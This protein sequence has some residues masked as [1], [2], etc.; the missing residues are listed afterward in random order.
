MNIIR[1]SLVANRSLCE[2]IR[3]RC[4][5]GLLV[6][7][8]IVMQ[9]FQ[10]K[11]AFVFVALLTGL[12]TCP[13]LAQLPT[14]GP[15]Y[16]I[17]KKDVGVWDCE[18]KAWSS[19]GA[20]PTIT[21]GRETNR[22]L[23][24]HW[25]ITDFQGNMMGMDF[26]GHGTYGYDAKKKKYVGTWVDSLGPYMMQTEGTYDKE[27]ETLTVQGDSP[28]PDGVTLFTYTMETK[29]QSG[30]RVMTMHMRPQGA[31]E[32]EN[33]KLFQMSYTKRKAKAENTR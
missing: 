32:A 10:S 13:A 9:C 18:I 19:P 17:L 27:S 12:C 11:L 30:K 20:K 29:Y 7:E 2:A 28:G 25:L 26:Q 24:G 22:M 6:E 4:P 21:Q 15:E 16:D 14:P 33:M 31:P 23:G 5:V 3:G 1:G 8:R